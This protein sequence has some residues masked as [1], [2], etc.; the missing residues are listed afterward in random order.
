MIMKYGGSI[1]SMCNPKFTVFTPT[2]NRAHLLERVFSSLQKQTF[3]SFEWIVI[4]DGSTDRTAE[5]VAEFA[6][7]LDCPVR[8]F[9]KS[10]EGK[11][12]AIND[13]LSYAAGEWFIVFDSDDWCHNA[14]L[15]RIAEEIALIEQRGDA[16]EYCA[17]STLK[18]YTSGQVVGDD[19]SR[20]SKYGASYVDRFNSGLKGDKWEIIKTAVHR[21]YMY[22]VQLGERYMAPSYAWLCMGRFYKTA[23]LNE[24]LSIIEYQSAGISRNNILHRASS[25]YSA[26]RHYELSIGLSRNFLLR[27]K[28]R[29]NR[30]RFK[31][32]AGVSVSRTFSGFM[33]FLF[34]VRDGFKLN[35]IRRRLARGK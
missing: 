25:P 33:G 5:V 13:A 32:H 14:A 20:F 35:E 12:R 15:E 31:A 18:T 30:E 34:F 11:V 24:P 6:K 7:K 1:A 28:M 9:Y 19:Y 16:D 17:I 4:D 29:I 2:Y 10:N 21:R 26:I 27:T 8:Y 22:D 3:K 23:F